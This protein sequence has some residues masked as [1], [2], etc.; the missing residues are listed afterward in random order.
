MSDPNSS[1]GW[2]ETTL[3]A[4]GSWTSGGTPSRSNLDY[5]GQG[6]PWVKTGE[7]KD[8]IIYKVEES[9]TEEGLAASA[10]R[11]LPPG[12]LLV[13]MYGATIGRLGVLGTEAATNQACAALLPLGTTSAVIPFL[14]YY[15][16][17]Q[18]ENLKA[19]GQG[20]AQ[21]N[22]S[23]ALLKAYECP[24]A[25]L[26][27]QRRIVAKLDALTSK[28]R[29]AKEALDAIP[30][31]IERFRQSVLAAAFRGDLTAEWRA[32]NPDVEPAEELLK[33]IRVERRRR[34]EEAE[35]AKM[36][37][38][39]K[40]PG[41]DRWKAKY[42]EPEPVDTEGLPELPEG[43]C[44][45]IAADVCNAVVDCHNKTAPYEAAGIR[46]LRTSNIRDGELVLEDVRFVSES[47][48]AFWSRRCPPA[49]GDVLFTREAPMGEAAM[50]PPDLRV[51]MGQRM[52]LLRANV[53]VLDASYLLLACQNPLIRQWANKLA[54]GTGV[55][56]LRVGDVERLPIPVCSPNEQGEVVRRVRTMLR[57]LKSLRT[58]LDSVRADEETLDR[59]IL[60]KAFRGEL[61][62]QDPNDEPASVLLERIKKEREQAAESETGRKKGKA[63]GRAPAAQGT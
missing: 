41:D 47:T 11:K 23:Q 63:R 55:Q 39:G 27:E 50:V 31:L 6:I 62:P 10:A 16:R 2:V 8:G 21:P 4:L 54:V 52:M 1:A 28:S 19:A 58:R 12:T 17:S 20:G 15:L 33:R 13:A 34:W 44:W 7:L 25:P 3:G 32:K 48:Y 51:C 61:V 46:L 40:A 57:Q 29:R 9:I 43:W 56:H 42:E 49:S 24:L 30:P 22:I 26:P 53:A 36:Q 38:K 45:A 60:A 37:A 14:F 18:R 59:A 5:Y 35:L